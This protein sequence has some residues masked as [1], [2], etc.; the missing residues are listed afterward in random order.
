MGRGRPWAALGGVLGQ[1]RPDGRAPPA[2]ARASG[3][4]GADPLLVNHLHANAVTAARKGNHHE[5]AEQL[6]EHIGE[7]GARHHGSRTTEHMEL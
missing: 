5:L 1:L 7:S 6:L 2:L 3:V 4:E